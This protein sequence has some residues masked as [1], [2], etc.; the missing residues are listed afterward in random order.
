MLMPSLTPSTLSSSKILI[1]LQCNPL[2]HK[3]LEQL[4]S[5][6]VL[7]LVVQL[8]PSNSTLYYQL[9]HLSILAWT[10]KFS[11]NFNS[12]KL[13]YNIYNK[14]LIIIPYKA[15]S[16]YLHLN[17]KTLNLYNYLFNTVALKVILQVRSLI[18]KHHLIN[19]SFH[20]LNSSSK[21]SIKIK[22]KMQSLKEIIRLEILR[23]KR[24]KILNLHLEA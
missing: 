2:L 13:T 17:N 11:H 6:K 21:T 8:I 12:H 7:S 1:I 20:K 22:L 23:F 4:S 18:I 3:I 5:A 14:W 24:W 10:S 16:N 15:K 19:N 9:F